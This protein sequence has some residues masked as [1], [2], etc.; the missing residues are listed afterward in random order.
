[1]WRL[2]QCR[3][4]LNTIHEFTHQ[5]MNTGLKQNSVIEVRKIEVL[6]YDTTWE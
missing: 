4:L 6:K 1:M 2:K 3:I 5:A